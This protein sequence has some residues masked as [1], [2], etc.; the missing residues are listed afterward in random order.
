MEN[1]G[2]FVDL[3]TFILGAWVFLHTKQACWLASN[4]DNIIVH[5]NV[6]TII[7]IYYIIYIIYASD[8]TWVCHMLWSFRIHG[9]SQQQP[10]TTYMLQAECD[11]AVYNMDIQF[12]LLGSD[13]LK[14]AEES[15]GSRWWKSGA[16]F[17]GASKTLKVPGLVM[18]FTVCDIENGPVEIV[19]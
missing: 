4:G 1:L 6:Y 2:F 15:L 5:V 16:R 3:L 8:A 10:F 13:A 12:R 17:R 19:D 9:H 14:T 7:Y 11:R 18:T